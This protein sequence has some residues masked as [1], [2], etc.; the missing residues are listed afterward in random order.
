MLFQFAAALASQAASPEKVVEPAIS[1]L[2]QTIIGALL[3]IS[4][5]ITILALWQLIKVQNSRV[6]DA[7]ASNDKIAALADKM[8][9]AFTGVQ[10]SVENLRR[11]EESSQQV[12]SS[13]KTTLDLLMA[14]RQLRPTP[15]SMPAVV[16]PKRKGEP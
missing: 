13:M 1:T 5:G 10:V 7:K 8:T 6:E 3:V 14:M 4:W 12:V 15:G 16:P 9:L 11:S 2:A